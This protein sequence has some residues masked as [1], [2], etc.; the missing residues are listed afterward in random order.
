M[1]KIIFLV[2]FLFLSSSVFGDKK[3][4]NFL[5]LHFYLR[6]KEDIIRF[7]TLTRGTVPIPYNEND[8]EDIKLKKEHGQRCLEAEI[9][10]K[11]RDPFFKDAHWI[12]IGKNDKKENNDNEDFFCKPN[13]IPPV[14]AERFCQYLGEQNNLEIGLSKMLKN[15]H[16]FICKLSKDNFLI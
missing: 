12:L 8:P 6:K 3:E 15:N 11:K 2:L 9:E 4:L 10:I 13:K 14:I 16:G 7:I 1:K 5:S